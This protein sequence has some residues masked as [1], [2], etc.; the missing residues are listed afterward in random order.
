MARS[1]ASE[2]SILMLSATETPNKLALS[3]RW[4]I[5]MTREL[6]SRSNSPSAAARCRSTPR[7]PVSCSRTMT[8]SSNQNAARARFARCCDQRRRRVS[9]IGAEMREQ[10]YSESAGLSLRLAL[11]GYCQ[12]EVRVIYCV[13]EP[14][15]CSGARLLRG[16]RWLRRRPGRRAARLD[17]DRRRAVARERRAGRSGAVL[18]GPRRRVA[19]RLGP[20]HRFALRDEE[21][22]RPSRERPG[23]GARRT[24]GR[25][26]LGVLP[27]HP[28]RSDAP[29]GDRVAL[30]RPAD[31]GRPRPPGPCARRLAGARDRRL[32]RR[33]H[34]ARPR[35]AFYAKA[36]QG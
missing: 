13:H 23:R 2:S 35:R 12:V 14:V 11:Q 9:I 16:A 24:R 15:P 22:V 34:T 3:W 5:A 21:R 26:G 32:P 20:L 19:A 30:A 28:H 25:L 1:T 18:R 31:A 4:I 29:S 27:A 7:E 33:R 36:L 17:R 10:A 8:A 6:R